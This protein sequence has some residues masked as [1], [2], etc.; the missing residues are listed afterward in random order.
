MPPQILCVKFIIEM[1]LGQGLASLLS[2]T[3]PHLHNVIHKYKTI[4][5]LKQIM[6]NVYYIE[7]EATHAYPFHHS[8]PQA[9]TRIPR[10]KVW[11]RVAYNYNASH[12]NHKLM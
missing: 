5:T 3:E 9:G 12:I 2:T 6:A 4:H 11:T 10:I 1:C 7:L 8:S